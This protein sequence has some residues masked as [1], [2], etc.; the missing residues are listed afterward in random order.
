MFFRMQETENWTCCLPEMYSR[1]IWRWSQKIMMGRCRYMSF[2]GALK[3]H[4][5]ELRNI[6]LISRSTNRKT[7][8]SLM[9]FILRTVKKNPKSCVHHRFMED[10]FIS[11]I[12]ICIVLTVIAVT[13]MKMAVPAK[14]QMLSRRRTI[15]IFKLL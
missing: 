15:K 6:I 2:S 14:R 7:W 4:I 10:Y 5:M 9:E 8:W 13:A 3:C 1:D 12:H 11:R